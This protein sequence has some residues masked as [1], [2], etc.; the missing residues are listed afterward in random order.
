[1]ASSPG[2]T[3]DGSQARAPRHAEGPSRRLP[4]VPERR[5]CSFADPQRLARHLIGAGCGMASLAAQ[6]FKDCKD[7]AVVS[8]GRREI[9][10]GEDIGDIFLDRT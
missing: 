2:K 9:E 3:V 8:V 1:M 7:P 5:P 4:R 10:F 6:E